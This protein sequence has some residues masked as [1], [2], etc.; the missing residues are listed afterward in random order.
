MCM[1]YKNKAFNKIH[2]KYQYIRKP[3]SEIKPSVTDILH[4][5]VFEVFSSFNN[6][7]GFKQN[8]RK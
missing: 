2:K 4:F 3:V 1:K 5:Y 8:Y 6:L 7:F